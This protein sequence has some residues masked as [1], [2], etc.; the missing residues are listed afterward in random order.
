MHPEA[1]AAAERQAGREHVARAARDFLPVMPPGNALLEEATSIGQSSLSPV[2]TPTMLTP[3]DVLHEA[4]ASI[5]YVYF[6]VDCLVSLLLTQDRHRPIEVAMV[7]NEGMVG[8]PLALGMRTSLVQA[9]VQ[10]SGGAWRMNARAFQEL[11]AR[12]SRLRRH[13]DG[14]IHALI[15]QLT[16]SAA[17]NAF[18]PVEARC[19]RWLLMARDRLRADE[20]ELTQEA[21]AQKLGVRR[22]GITVAAG[23]LQRSGSITYSRGRIRILD[24][25]RL[26]AAA[27]ECYRVVDKIDHRYRSTERPLRTAKMTK[28]I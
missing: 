8:V 7:G 2:L 16:Q 25:Q 28:E 12:K 1:G 19:A 26:A 14:Y 4:H 6:P 21:L 10:C 13:I 22:V 17:C 23:N 15:G 27:C 18:H 24:S 11:L 20:F 9:V 5:R 3:G